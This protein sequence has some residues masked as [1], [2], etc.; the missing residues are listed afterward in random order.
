MPS[1]VVVFMPNHVFPMVTGANIQFLDGVMSDSSTVWMI[2]DHQ[3]YKML[4]ANPRIRDS[5]NM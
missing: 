5:V 2:Y 4:K 1:D 3:V